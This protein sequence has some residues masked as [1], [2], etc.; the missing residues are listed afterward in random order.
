MRSGHILLIEDD[1][2]DQYLFQQMINELGVDNELRFFA[3]GLEALDYLR[4]TEEQPFIILC[5]VNM[6]TMNGIELR[7]VIDQDEQLKKKAVPFIFLST[8]ASPVVVR[9]SYETTIQ[10]FFKKA[11]DYE[12]AKKQLHW[13]IGYWLHC[14]HPHNQDWK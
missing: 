11:D 9:D 4:V 14:V 2:D 7:K 10:G 12:A 3:N 6:P 1:E 13:I 8:Y 5:D